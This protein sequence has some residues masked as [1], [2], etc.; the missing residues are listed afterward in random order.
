[1][2]A[3]G[4]LDATVARLARLG[5]ARAFSPKRFR[6]ALDGVADGSRPELLRRLLT[7]WAGVALRDEDALEAYQAAEQ[8]Q[9]ALR[10][11]LG[12]PVSLLTALVHELHTRR[13]L[14]VE[15]RLLPERDLHALRVNAITDPLT[16]LYNRRFM[17]DHLD[18][19]LSRA[20]RSGGVVSLIL[21]NL[22]GF[23][24]INDR[25][26]HPVGD[27][28]LV[29]T[30]RRIRES[31][32]VV[33][34]GCRYGG[35]EFVAV[36]PNAD[37]VHGLVAAERIQRKVAGIRLPVSNGI[38][39]GLNYGISTFPAD[40]RTP[41]FLVK[42][43]DVRLF[44][45]RR[46]EAASAANRRYHPRF[47]VQGL[48]L[49]LHGS[50]QRDVTSEVRDIGYGGLSFTHGDGKVPPHIEADLVQRFSPEVHP[51]TMKAVSVVPM[52]EGRVRV[53][54]AYVH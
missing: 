15:P 48:S 9:A 54:C 40:G 18:R 53:G 38:R 51:V 17:L 35:D 30:A 39:V 23:K 44:A 34:A 2:K 37:F 6:K 4:T 46:D 29:R 31:L 27:S 3:A 11:C 49:N 24:S 7:E 16:G 20:E 14:L 36:L 45:A 42:A 10:R 13:G 19:E 5:R 47:A 21:M 8:S 12:Q 22:R 43:S 26:G 28:V 33:D 41:A 50:R 1:V 25:L 52:A 32:R